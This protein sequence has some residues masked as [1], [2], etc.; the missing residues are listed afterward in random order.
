[1]IGP[2]LG[3]GPFGEFVAIEWLQV[4]AGVPILLSAILLVFMMLKHLLRLADV[5]DVAGVGYL[6]MIASGFA[7]IVYII[8][9]ACTY[10]GL[11]WEGVFP[12]RLPQNFLGSGLFFLLGLAIDRYPNL[13]NRIDDWHDRRRHKV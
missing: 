10:T 6:M 4:V 9:F 8:G 1:M 12:Q 5:E 2:A 7:A 3:S 11:M 13:L